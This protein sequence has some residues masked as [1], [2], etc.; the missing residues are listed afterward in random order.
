MDTDDLLA[1]DEQEQAPRPGR[2]QLAQQAITLAMQSRWDEAVETNRQILDLGHPD[3]ETYNR[4][5]KAFKELARISEAREAYQQALQID[6]ANAIA[7]RSLEQ[8]SRI[9]D[10]EAAELAK[11]AGQK[12]DPQ[13][14]TEETGKTGVV[15]LQP[16]A[17]PEVLATVS[18]GD[19]VT[20][21]QQDG[22]LIV[23][24]VD[25]VQLGQVE[26]ALATRLTRLMQT[27]NEYQAGV[28]GQDDRTLRVIIRETFQ[29]AQNA[30]R[31]SFPPRTESLPRPYLREGIMRRGAGE[32]EDEEDLDVDLQ[33]DLGEDE[34][35]DAS[36][37]G[38]HEGGLDES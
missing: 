26:D 19:R 37:F 21:E 34:D 8:L 9:S 33:D 30:G 23:T 28:V 35:E 38:F 15:T 12:L 11:R 3:A 32:E 13:F 24:T 5:G 20:L 1:V 31:I 14:F 18:A 36:E 7:E 16:L 6:P 10:A 2:R 25:G 27:G 29:A 22:A 4:L 17:P